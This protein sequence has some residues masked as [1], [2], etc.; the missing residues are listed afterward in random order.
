MINPLVPPGM[1]QASCFSSLWVKYLCP[2][3]FVSVAI[4]T[5][6]RQIVQ[7]VLPSGV[8]RVDMVNLK[9]VTTVYLGRLAVFTP[10]IRPF[11]NGCPNRFRDGQ[12]CYSPFSRLASSSATEGRGCPRRRKIDNALAR[13][14]IERCQVR[15]RWAC[16]ASSGW[17]SGRCPVRAF[18]W[19]KRVRS[20]DEM[21]GF[22]AAHKASSLKFNMATHS[23]RNSAGKSSPGGAFTASVS[24]TKSSTGRRIH[25]AT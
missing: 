14:A 25:S 21:D 8:G 3:S 18:S 6:Q 16:S 17:L 23:A 24:T 22:V 15:N 9:L 5:S 20:A 11:P 1:K 7:C 13:R 4:A 2:S 19:D 10:A 12:V